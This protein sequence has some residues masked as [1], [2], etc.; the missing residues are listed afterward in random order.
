[1][2]P[3]IAPLI[4]PVR[5]SVAGAFVFGSFVVGSFVFSSWR[6]NAMGYLFNRKA[7]I[8]NDSRRATRQAG[9]E[10]IGFLP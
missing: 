9:S 7:L 10:S 4:A 5:V 3:V 2:A 8:Q 1:M 6:M